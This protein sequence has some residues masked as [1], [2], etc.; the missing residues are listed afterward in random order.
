MKSSYLLQLIA[1]DGG[2]P[3]LSGQQKIEV[4]VTE[5]VNS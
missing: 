5:Y 3:T 2:S 1:Y 4:I